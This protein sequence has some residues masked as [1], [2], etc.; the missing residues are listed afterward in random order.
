MSLEPFD[1]VL[2]VDVFLLLDLILRSEVGER[3]R[4]WGGRRRSD[5]QPLLLAVTIALSTHSASSLALPL[6]PG[7]PKPPRSLA[8]LAL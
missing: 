3:G 4:S 6:A 8:R 7:V 2:G 5:G 1:V